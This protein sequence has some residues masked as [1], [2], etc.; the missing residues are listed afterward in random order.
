VVHH[1]KEHFAHL[2]DFVQ[3]GLMALLPMPADDETSIATCNDVFCNLRQE[4]A[5]AAQAAST[6][7]AVDRRLVFAGGRLLGPEDRSSGAAGIGR[8]R[9]PAAKVG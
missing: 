1:A 6:L 7:V 2:L 5:L 8:R 9:R 4:S 3:S